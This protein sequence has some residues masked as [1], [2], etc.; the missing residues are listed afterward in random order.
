MCCE[1]TE[2]EKGL[3]NECRVPDNPDTVDSGVRGTHSETPQRLVIPS[4]PLPWLW[5][6]AWTWGGEGRFQQTPPWA[7][8]QDRGRLALRPQRTLTLSPPQPTQL[9]GGRLLMAWGQATP[10]H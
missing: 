6:S 10:G 7:D 2:R 5:A 1:L 4:G 8:L 9:P 3:V